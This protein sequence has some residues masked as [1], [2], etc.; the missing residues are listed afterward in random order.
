MANELYVAY[1]FNK[2]KNKKTVRKS[3]LFR[4]DNMLYI[5]GYNTQY[6]KANKNG[7]RNTST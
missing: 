6:E 5:C 4:F 2:L 7:N 3:I 1:I